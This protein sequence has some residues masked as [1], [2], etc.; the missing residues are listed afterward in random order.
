MD[1]DTDT[2]MTATTD[3]VRLLAQIRVPDKAVRDQVLAGRVREEDKVK[4]QLALVVRELEPLRVQ[5]AVRVL[6]QV[7]QTVLPPEKFHGTQKPQAAR[8][9]Q[10]Q[11]GNPQE[12]GVLERVQQIQNKLRANPLTAAADLVAF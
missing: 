3:M 4:E 5:V 8:R 6:K 10:V 7:L 1:M 2:G 9:T 11:V 12:P